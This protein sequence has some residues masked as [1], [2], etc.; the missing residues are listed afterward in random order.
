MFPGELRPL[1]ELNRLLAQSLKTLRTDYHGY[2]QG[3]LMDACQHVLDEPEQTANYCRCALC[4]LCRRDRAVRERRVLKE[5][6]A[7]V[8]A[9]FQDDPPLLAFQTFTLRD[10]LPTEVEARA[11]V[12]VAGFRKLLRKRQLRHVLGWA[13]TIATKCS[14]VDPEFENLHMHAILLFPP[15]AAEELSLIDWNDLWQRCA[16][17]LARDTDPDWGIAREPEAVVAYLTKHQVWDFD[18]DAMIGV[19]D[20]CRY[21]RRVRF[22]HHKFSSGGRLKEPAFSKDDILSGLD[23]AI[24]RST[25]RSQRRQL[26]RHQVEI[27]IEEV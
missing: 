19:R 21:V 17:N 15:G 25:I 6:L 5:L 20:P 23:V 1:A 10:A 8:C 9:G 14:S 4:L 22:G 3:H 7:S 12:L 13:R 16:G 11:K 2:I 27:P 26:R 18:E 24:S